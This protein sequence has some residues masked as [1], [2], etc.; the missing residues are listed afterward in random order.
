MSHQLF[1]LHLSKAFF[2]FFSILKFSF[3]WTFYYS[4][5]LLEVSLII[6]WIWL[7][8]INLNQNNQRKNYSK[9]TQS[10]LGI[11][12][13]SKP[14]YGYHL[15]GIEFLFPI[16][17]FVLESIGEASAYSH[18]QK[19]FK[20]LH[21]SIRFLLFV[22]LIYSYLRFQIFFLKSSIQFASIIFNVL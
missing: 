13:F 19:M 7:N 14:Y 1:Y 9:F 21:F 22:N 2:H 11:F 18:L 17:L 3:I 15:E 20:L 6:V 12:K 8:K 16:S 4:F 10:L 5:F